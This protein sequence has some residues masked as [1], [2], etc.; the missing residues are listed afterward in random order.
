MTPCTAFRKRAI[1][2][3]SAEAVP[4]KCTTLPASAVPDANAARSRQCPA[5]TRSSWDKRT[6]GR[7][8]HA[9]GAGGAEHR[10]F[11]PFIHSPW[12]STTVSP[13]I[14]PDRRPHADVQLAQLLLRDLGRR[15]GERAARGL[16]LRNAMTSRIDSA[17]AISI[18]RRSRPNAMPP[19][20]GAPY[21]SASS[22]KPNFFCASSAP[23]RAV[24]I[25]WTACRYGGYAP[26][27]RRSPSR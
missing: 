3:H 24:R 21:L 15:V 11:E 26:S 4:T 1:D 6:C 16:C 14:T 18:T 7:R 8:S 12:T 9:R 17:P 10:E 13:A 25:R 20:G 23:M 19:C 5:R 22:R 27:P 2:E